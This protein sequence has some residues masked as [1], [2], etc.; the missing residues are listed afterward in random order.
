MKESQENQ[1]GRVALPPSWCG[2]ICSNAMNE[3]CVESCAVKRDCS[4]FEV[5]PELKLGDMPRFPLPESANMTKEERFTSV[6]VYLAKVVDHLQG[7]EDEPDSL[8]IRRNHDRSGSRAV[9]EDIKGKNVLPGSPERDP[10][11]PAWPERPGQEVGPHEVAGAED[12]LC[13]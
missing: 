1:T 7:V 2:S 10:A 9:L 11:Y 6:T 4:A 13:R 12:G 8:P 5:K 3:I